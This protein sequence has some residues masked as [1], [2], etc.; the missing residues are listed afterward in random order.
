MS[1]AALGKLDPI[2]DYSLGKLIRETPQEK[3]VKA[4]ATKVTKVKSQPQ[5]INNNADVMSQGATH[6]K[7]LN[8]I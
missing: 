5:Y 8:I 6:F 2:I 7:R 3:I 1:N 4:L